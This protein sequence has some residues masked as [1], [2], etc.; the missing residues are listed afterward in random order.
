MLAHLPYEE[1]VEETFKF[2]K[3]MAGKWHDRGLQNF[4]W[5]GES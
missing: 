5:N 2:R 4:T 1:T 3:E